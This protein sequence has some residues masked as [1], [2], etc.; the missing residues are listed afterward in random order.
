MS[1]EIQTVNINGSDLS[2]SN[3]NKTYGLTIPSG[4]EVVSNSLRI[5]SGRTSFNSQTDFSFTTPTITFSGVSFLDADE[6]TIIYTIEKSVVTP[7]V[8]LNFTSVL[9]FVNNVK[10]LM[11]IPNA[12][13]ASEDNTRY[14]ANGIEILGT[15]DNSRLIFFLNNPGVIEETLTLSFGADE[16]N[17]TDLTETTDYTFNSDNSQVI[18][19][20][21]GRTAI[22]T[23]DLYGIYDY[24]T[25]GL[26]NN[27]IER[28]LFWAEAKIERISEQTFANFSDANPAYRKTLNEP[29]YLNN[30]SV[31]EIGGSAGKA[32]ELMYQPLVELSTTVNGA[33]TTGGTTLTLADASGFIT[34]GA[35][36]VGGN[37][38]VYTAK[39]GNDLTVPST[40]PSIA[41]GAV[42]RG[43]V[44][45]LSREPEGV[46]PSFTVLDPDTE[47]IIDFVQGKV[48][49]LNNAFLGEF[50]ATDVRFPERRF[51]RISSLSAWHEEGQNPVVP[52]EI[53]RCAYA[54]AE[55]RIFGSII[56]K[57][58]MQGLNDFRP[59][60]LNAND[61][62]INS[63]IVSYQTL[64]VGSSPYNKTKIS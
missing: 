42:V 2:G 54:I 26:L 35:I 13:T 30:P 51:V 58:H 52:D 48:Q 46:D 47:Y 56:Q 34:A 16:F 11:K 43:E 31:G 32:I 37:K 40:T 44:V 62:D 8:T 24:N 64:N 1:Q 55:K 59:T 63:I 57:K 61:D 20:T 39:T 60:L 49:L 9:G 10:S 3:P 23:N 36:Y 14:G 17:R 38:V 4:F 45:E 15:G 33:Y 21:T 50:S 19:T 29:F 18:L 12:D 6:I 53:E 7:T 22:G 41:D 25:L 27:E 5:Q 28:E